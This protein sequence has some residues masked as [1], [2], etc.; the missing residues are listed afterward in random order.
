MAT[1]CLVT[2]F[3]TYIHMYYAYTCYSCAPSLSTH[4]DL[5]CIDIVR[6]RF[7]LGGQVAVCH[8]VA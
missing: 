2:C 3:Q 8:M 1:L 6:L 5:L 4:S 7:G